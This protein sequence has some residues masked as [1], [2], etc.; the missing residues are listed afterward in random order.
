M[1]KQVCC[2]G[3]ESCDAEALT[4]RWR[5]GTPACGG[6]GVA[7]STSVHGQRQTGCCSWR[8]RPQITSIRTTRHGARSPPATVCVSAVTGGAAAEPTNP[9]TDLPDYFICA[10]FR[11]RWRHNCVIIH[12]MQRQ[13]QRR[14][15]W[16]T[17]G[18]VR[19]HTSNCENI[20]RRCMHASFAVV[21][22]F[23]ARSISALPVAVQGQVR[24]V[25]SSLQRPLRWCDSTSDLVEMPFDV[26]D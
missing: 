23:R 3:R 22:S 7:A 9:T 12:R 5:R 17:D 15:R 19:P 16:S 18:L 24:C 13:R 21:L 1:D 6:R 11:R 14:Q 8:A 10:G 4:G 26:G 20:R 25:G 2:R